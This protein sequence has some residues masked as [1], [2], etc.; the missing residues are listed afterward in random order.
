[1]RR[2]RTD[3]CGFESTVVF[4]VDHS[5]LHGAYIILTKTLISPI[6]S[7]SAPKSKLNCEVLFDDLAFEVRW[8]VAGESI[9]I[10][11]V[12]KL[13]KYTYYV[14]RS[15][16]IIFTRPLSLLLISLDVV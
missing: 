13:G 1:M 7:H 3:L 5:N 4:V 12:A 14:P 10:Q 6:V 16:P 8:A 15:L 9:V 11:L 2:R